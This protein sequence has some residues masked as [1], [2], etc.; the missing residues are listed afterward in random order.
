MY[1]AVFFDEAM[2]VMD[3]VEAER[4]PL[5]TGLPSHL[6]VGDEGYETL[7]SLLGLDT[8]QRR[9]DVAFTQFVRQRLRIAGRGP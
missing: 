9:K 8:T 4:I 5:P 7:C 1:H 2:H 3:F 6:S